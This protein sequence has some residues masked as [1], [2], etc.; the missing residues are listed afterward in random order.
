MKSHPR[1]HFCKGLESI[2]PTYVGA[3]STLSY[4]HSLNKYASERLEFTMP[5]FSHW[6][7]STGLYR[8][9]AYISVRRDTM[10]KVE[11]KQRT[12]RQMFHRG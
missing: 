9:K 6:R 1:K 12:R 4:V 10:H 8:P 5:H 7:F 3:S 11:I 2:W